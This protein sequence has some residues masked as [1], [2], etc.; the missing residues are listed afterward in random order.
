MLY[1]TLNNMPD[2]GPIHDFIFTDHALKEMARRAI[3][4]EDVKTVLEKL[5]QIE[6][7]RE[8]RA[9]YQSKLEM[10]EPLKMYLLR[11][12]VDINP[13]PPAVVT[14]YR[15]SKIEKYWR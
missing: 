10:G 6:L 13:K 12:F 15:T 3:T 14:V 5:E 4:Q 9:V 8:G 7:V 2:L 1:F 11:V